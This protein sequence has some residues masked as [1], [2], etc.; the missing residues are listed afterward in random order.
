VV[1]EPIRIEGLREFLR[2]VKRANADLPKAVRL[3]GN[4]AADI[5]VRTAKPRVPQRTGRAAGTIRARS[6]Q[7]EARVAA[8][9]ARVPYYP[10]LDFGGRVGRN[11]ATKRPFIKKGRYIWAAYADHIPQIQET[12]AESLADVA[13][14][15][16]LGVD[17]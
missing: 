12:M 2:A 13:R 15:A 14:Q 11:H 4:A 1:A 5:V 3:A 16:G 10:W 9:G 17:R 7:S 6:T 8:G